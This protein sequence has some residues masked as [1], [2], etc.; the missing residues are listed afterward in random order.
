MMTC[1]FCTICRVWSCRIWWLEP[2]CGLAAGHRCLCVGGQRSI[3]DSDG[4]VLQHLCMLL[5]VGIGAAELPLCPA[6]VNGTRWLLTDFRACT[7]A[8]NRRPVVVEGSATDKALQRI[9]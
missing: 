8:V 6:A 4:L 3:S 5:V 9:S 1:S 7:A 2:T